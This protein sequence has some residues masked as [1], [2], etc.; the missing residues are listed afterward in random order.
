MNEACHIWMKL[1]HM[2]IRHATYEWGL[3]HMNT[4]S[5]EWVTSHMNTKES[6]VN[7]KES[8]MTIRNSHIRTRSRNGKKKKK[9]YAFVLG[10]SRIVTCDYL[11][12]ICDMT[13]SYDVVFMWLVVDMMYEYHGTWIR[14]YMNIMSHEYNMCTTS[15]TACVRGRIYSFAEYRLFCRAFLQKRP[16]FW[17]SLAEEEYTA[18]TSRDM[19]YSHHVVFIWRIVDIRYEYIM[20]HEYYII[21]IYH[22]TRILHHIWISFHMMAYSCDYFVRGRRHNRDVSQSFQSV[23][24]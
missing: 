11:V 17:G 12:F 14:H 15:D 4:T 16:T 13:H 18:E 3:S 5:H 8:H 23:T 1:C 22:A 20:P 7:A 2:W 9:S 6:H 10:M 24:K 19:T 21:C